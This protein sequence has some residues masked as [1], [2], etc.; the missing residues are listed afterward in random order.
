M[1]EGN[2]VECTYQN[3]QEKGR[4]VMARISSTIL[5]TNDAFPKLELQMVSG[6]TLKLPAGLGEGYSVVLL[7]RGHW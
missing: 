6:E 5:D 1:G 4:M 3:P 7:Y 2:G